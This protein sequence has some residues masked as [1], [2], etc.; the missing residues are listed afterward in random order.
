[1]NNNKS[2]N[3]TRLIHKLDESWDIGVKY[4]KNTYKSD[5]QLQ[6]F[7]SSY[8]KGYDYYEDHVD[9]GKCGIMRRDA[10]E[11]II[12]HIKTFYY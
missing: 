5:K 12:E 6:K 2:V 1:M 9:S 8:Y 10:V 11:N 3:Y 7:V 4:V